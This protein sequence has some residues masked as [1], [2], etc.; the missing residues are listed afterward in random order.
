MDT[1]HH[2]VSTQEELNVPE[3]AG[4]LS[5]GQRTVTTY[6][7]IVS[8]S[9]KKRRYENAIITKEQTLKTVYF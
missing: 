3:S 8:G 1:L 9:N 7:N 4:H 2:P 5:S 6:T